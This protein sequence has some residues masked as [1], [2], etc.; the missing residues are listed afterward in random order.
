MLGGPFKMDTPIICPIVKSHESLA[1]LAP[2]QT[3]ALPK[4]TSDSVALAEV[5]RTE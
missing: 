1:A 2:H 4:F 5:T 3:K